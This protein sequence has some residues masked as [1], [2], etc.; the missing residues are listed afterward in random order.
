M[1]DADALAGLRLLVAGGDLAAVQVAQGRLAALG[2][3]VTALAGDVEALARAATAAPPAAIVAVD[4]TERQLRER[5]DPFDLKQGPPVIGLQ[6]I[7]VADEKLGVN[8]MPL[9]GT[10]GKT[11]WYYD[12]FSEDVMKECP[13][14]K[15]RRI[16]FS[17]EDAKPQDATLRFECF[18]PVVSS[19]TEV[20]GKEA[21]NS[22]CSDNSECEARQS[23]VKGNNFQLVCDDTVKTCQIS[24]MQDTECPDSWVCDTE[25]QLC[26][27]PTCPP[28]NLR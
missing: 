10:D 7:S 23:T 3:D 20:L 12:T 17:S 22:P 6:A 9:E 1:D 5:L 28:P 16:S 15:R 11:G 21:V 18:Q 24:C 8:P 2:A 14:G 25:R 27:N 4:A 13:D 26:V 19:N